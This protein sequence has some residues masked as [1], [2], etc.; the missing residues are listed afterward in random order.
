M[1][2][3]QTL[4]HTRAQQVVLLPVQVVTLWYRAPELLL[5]A[6]EYS[7]GVDVWSMGCVFAEMLNSK[8]LFKTASD[9]SEVRQLLTACF[10][11]GPVAS[12]I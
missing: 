4:A 1:S 6:P 7:A 2:S 3:W 11:P 5:G 8:P 10:Q 9:G 12:S